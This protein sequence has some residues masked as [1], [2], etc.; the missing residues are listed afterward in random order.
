MTILGQQIIDAIESLKSEPIKTNTGAG[1]G[2][3]LQSPNALQFREMLEQYFQNIIWM[4]PSPSD[5][6]QSQYYKDAKYHTR[7]PL[8]D[9]SDFGFG[10]TKE[11][12][13]KI[14]NTYE[15]WRE[16]HKKA[17]KEAKKLALDDFIEAKINFDNFLNK[18]LLPEN[19]TSLLEI[20]KEVE[21]ISNQNQEH[22]LNLGRGLSKTDKIGLNLL[23][24]NKGK[25][26]KYFSNL[27]KNIMTD[28]NNLFD[29]AEFAAY[30][31]F[32]IGKHDEDKFTKTQNI[33]INKV[34]KLFENINPL[35][36]MLKLKLASKAKDSEIITDFLNL[37]KMGSFNTDIREFV[38]FNES[39]LS[40]NIGLKS[41]RAKN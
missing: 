35:S 19:I 24:E 20:I 34:I 7:P 11:E 4:P 41:F 25:D 17:K 36:E 31:N 2:F 16:T 9:F 21:K 8:Q 32:V 22:L 6:E 29:A 38:A 13:Q 18:C 26:G 39:Q 27:A 23:L 1:A 10:S 12:N 28:P 5:I 33:T 15:K 40:A 30:M 3:N 37:V 14:L